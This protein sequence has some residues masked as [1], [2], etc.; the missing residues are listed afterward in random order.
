MEGLN[1]S[2]VLLFPVPNA[3][4]GTTGSKDPLTK[5]VQIQASSGSPSQKSLESERLHFLSLK[6]LEPP[7]H[8][9][10]L[11]NLCNVFNDT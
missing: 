2:P 4:G 5:A 3:Q 9:I 6:F 10:Q 8:P 7:D 11:F 1:L